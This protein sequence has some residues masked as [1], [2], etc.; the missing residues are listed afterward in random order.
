MGISLFPCCP[1]MNKYPFNPMIRN[2]K[3]SHRIIIRVLA[4]TLLLFILVLSIFYVVSRKRI[5]EFARENAIHIAENAVACIEQ[6]LRPMEKVPRILAQVMELHPVPE[7]S[8]FVMLRAVLEN[9]DN[10]FGAAVAFEPHFFPHKGEYF[11]PYAYRDGDQI[12]TMTLGGELYDYFHMDWYQIPKVLGNPYW[13]EPYFDEGGGEMLMATYSVPFYTREDGQRRFAGIATVDISLEWLTGIVADIQI[14]ETGYAFMLSRS[15]VV[16]THPDLRNIM[17]ETMFSIAEERGLPLLREI[18]RDMIAGRSQFREHGLKRNGHTTWIYHTPLPSSEWSIGVVYLNDEMYASLHQIGLVM[19]LLIGGG[20]I[21][22]TLWVTQVVNRLAAPLSA[23]ATSARRIAQ[24]HFDTQLPTVRT[25]DEMKQL[26]DAFSHMQKELVTY[27]ENL[28]EATAAKEK[29]ESELRIAREIQ[30]SMIPHTFPPFPDLPQIDLYAML[31]SAREV[32]GDLYDFFVVDKHRF[33]FAIGDVSGKGVPASLFMA[34]TRTLLRTISDKEKQPGAIL[35][36]LNKSLA[37]NNDSNMFVT[38]FLGILD[39]KTGLLTYANAGHNPPVLV[40]S[41]GEVEVFEQGKTIPLGLFEDFEY[42]EASMNLCPGDKIF[43][44]TDGVSEA[45]NQ[46]QELFGEERM[47]AVLEGNR[48]I[49]PRE[50]IGLM[51]AAVN[52]HVKDF[53][54]SDDLTM[55]SILYKG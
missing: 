47:M 5:A 27:I 13:T 14:F 16:V 36:A 8:L 18:G 50:C 2:N 42:T 20:L 33:I 34:M 19:I 44:Y 23:F 32:G 53:P 38:F 35:K 45:E 10:I 9:N 43:T 11:S 25:K 51:E 55:M 37:H 1:S 39:L 48:D 15:G 3:L 49:Q 54:Q 46:E 17:N 31:K 29:I 26:H 4:F 28:R 52:A 41:K 40:R 12:R 30:L 24:G 21:L 6:E 22:L 7:D